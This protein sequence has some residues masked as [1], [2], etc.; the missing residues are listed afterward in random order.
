[1]NPRSKTF[2]PLQ[3]GGQS[4]MVGDLNCKSRT[5]IQF[6]QKRTAFAIY[7]NIGAEISQFNHIGTAGGQLQ[8]LFPERDTQLGE[9]R[10]GIRMTGNRLIELNRHPRSAVAN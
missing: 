4:R 3:T 10:S 5:C 8:M 9:V 7:D 1:M 6:Q 2:H